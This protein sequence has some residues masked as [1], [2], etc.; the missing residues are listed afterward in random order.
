MGMPS[1][2]EIARG[3]SGSLA[4]AP[5]STACAV[6]SDGPRDP[7]NGSLRADAAELWVQNVEEARMFQPDHGRCKLKMMAKT[8]PPIVSNIRSM[9]ICHPTS[10]G[11][12][13]R[14]RAI[15]VKQNVQAA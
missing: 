12:N 1:L 11:C 7:A 15:I 5:L 2:A 3:V 10:C 14:S 4:V 6:R 8:R 13:P 9:A